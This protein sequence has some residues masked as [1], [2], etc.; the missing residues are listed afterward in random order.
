M[1]IMTSGSIHQPVI[2]DFSRRVFKVDESER[3]KVTRNLFNEAPKTSDF[4]AK[5][6]K[7]EQKL[8]SLLHEKKK[9]QRKQMMI[10]K[11]LP[12]MMKEKK[13]AK[14]VIPENCSNFS[15]VASRNNLGF[16]P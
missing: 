1:N 4:S 13:R 15:G 9:Q 12:Y 11:Q 10:Q 16:T 14:Q 5:T 7:I 3:R 2:R 6:K 8:S